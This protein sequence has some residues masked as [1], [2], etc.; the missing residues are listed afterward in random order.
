MKTPVVVIV[1]SVC[2]V[3]LGTYGA[4]SQ[5]QPARADRPAFAVASVRPHK[6]DDKRPSSSVY[7]RNGVNFVDRAAGF[8]VAEAYHFPLGRVVGPESLTDEKLWGLL[9]ESY[10]VVA[11]ADRDVSKE[12]LR[13]MLQSLLAERFRLSLHVQARVAPVYKLT[14]AKNGPRLQ[15]AD[16]EGTF[17]ILHSRDAV[18]FQ[19]TDMMRFSNFLTGRVD[20]VVIDQTGLKGSYNFTLKRPED[21]EQESTKPT[22][23][24]SD[25]IGPDSMGS[26]VLAD[27]LKALGLQLVKDRA[28]VE[29]LVIDHVERATGN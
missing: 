11:K 16:G 23:M 7:T 4:T 3:V 22:A 27:S 2:A 29:Y 21:P 24:K 26:N 14:I 28:P 13:L 12:E 18:I 25:Q 6:S 5:A 1:V 19:Y 8:I 20:R 15:E 17:N 9:S 10:D